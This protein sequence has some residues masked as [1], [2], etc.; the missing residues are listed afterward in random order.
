MDDLL[1]LESIAK[2]FLEGRGPAFKDWWPVC[3]AVGSGVQTL[4]L[5]KGG[6]SEGRAG[7][8]FRH[9]VFALYPTQYH[10]ENGSADAMSGRRLFRPP[11]GD[12]DEPVSIE[13]VVGVARA[14][15]ISDLAT[16]EALDPFHIWNP[17]IVAER[18]AYGG[19]SA[20]HLAVV[21]AYRLPRPWVFPYERRFSGCR[22]WITLPAA[23]PRVFEGM[24]P[25]LSDGAFAEIESRIESALQDR[26][27]VNWL[28]ARQC[29]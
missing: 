18:F 25:V 4:L 7:F 29:R 5:R 13:V 1:F 2:P 20:L 23:S 14:G 6:I 3:D 15:I 27:P 26:I 9:P 8:A 10:V 11:G 21:R 28:E 22:S 16:A 24:A 19:Q 12:S 17:S